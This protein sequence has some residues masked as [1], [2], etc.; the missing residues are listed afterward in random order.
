MTPV[1]TRR[2]VLITNFATF[3]GGTSLAEDAGMSDFNLPRA[4]EVL[5]AAEVHEAPSTAGVGTV[6]GE[7][8]LAHGERGG[9]PFEGMYDHHPID[10]KAGKVFGKLG[11]GKKT[12]TKVLQALAET[13]KDKGA[14]KTM[15][16]GL[17]VAGAGVTAPLSMLGPYYGDDK[18][19]ESKGG[20]AAASG[21]KTTADVLA[22]IGK[23][24][25][26]SALPKATAGNL[27]L[28]K[29][30]SVVL[31]VMDML[32]PEDHPLKLIPHVANGMQPAEQAKKAIGGGVDAAIPLASFARGKKGLAY[33][34]AEA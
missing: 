3:E 19:A 1:A 23:E 12:A 32:L 17:G 2:G 22:A 16:K 15:S 18:I 21:V 34:Q 13:A 14:G 29:G 27:G 28:G 33:Q 30:E 10:K 11:K 8:G 20:H 9:D 31:G 25:G 26:K 5:E 24:T 7:H 4:E 6:P